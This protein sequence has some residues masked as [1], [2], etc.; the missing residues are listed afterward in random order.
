M[1]WWL[2]PS[3][4]H[5]VDSVAENHF[6]ERWF[7][8]M[9]QHNCW[10]WK[11]YTRYV[12]QTH[13]RGTSIQEHGP[14]FPNVWRVLG[15]HHWADRA[16]S[17]EDT[18]KNIYHTDSAGNYCRWNRD[19]VEQQTYDVCVFRSLRPRATDT[20]SHATWQKD[21]I[22]PLSSWGSRISEWSNI[23]LQQGHQE[24]CRQA[25]TLTTTGLAEVEGRIST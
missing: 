2:T 22:N 18:G 14:T 13:L 23:Y 17:E 19:N 1:T 5:S 6:Q 9:R 21:S 3:N 24:E 11:R 12:N 8:T 25:E 16:G 15:A 10:R 4:W 7:L 20:C